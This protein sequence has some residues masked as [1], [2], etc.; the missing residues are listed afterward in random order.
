MCLAQHLAVI[1]ICRAAFAP[2]SYV[3]SI[4]FVEL[5][6]L[7]AN[8]LM[9]FGTLWAIAYTLFFGLV[10]LTGIH[11]FLHAILKDA[12]VKQTLVNF[13]T[14]HIFKDTALVVD[15]LVSI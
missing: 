2:C 8:I 3:V 10:C 1:N 7:G 15:I 14:E 13:S 12:D 11:R 9:P 6:N 4:H 5:V